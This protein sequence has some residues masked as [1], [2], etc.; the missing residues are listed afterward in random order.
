MLRYSG[1]LGI[2]QQT[3]VRPGIWEETVTEVPV[4]GTVRNRTET[5]DGADSV[6]PRYRTTTS[7]SVPARGQGQMDNS[8][9]R[10]L[11]YKGKRWQIGSIVDDYPN[12]VIYIGEV[13]NGPHPE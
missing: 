11:T 13:Y 9:I 8:D 3:E 5:L 6:L 4:L 1:K 12:L 10:Y 7:V 2:A